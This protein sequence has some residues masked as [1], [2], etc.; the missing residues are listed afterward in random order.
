M[1]SL[2]DNQDNRECNVV[3][4]CR[5]GLPLIGTTG[6]TGSTGNTGNPLFPKFPVISART[7]T[8]WPDRTQAGHMVDTYSFIIHQC[9]SLGHF[10]HE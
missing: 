8:T 4:T 6:T 9:H 10:K 7:W 5:P 2:R 3:F 1:L